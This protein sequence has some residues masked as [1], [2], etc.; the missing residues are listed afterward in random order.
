MVQ[1]ARLCPCRLPQSLPCGLSDQQRR[2]Q[3]GQG[4]RTVMRARFGAPVPVRELQPLFFTVLLLLA[5]S[6][7]GRQHRRRTIVS[8]PLS[9]RIMQ[10]SAAPTEVSIR[11]PMRSVGVPAIRAHR[12]FGGRSDARR[13]GARG[14]SG[15][16]ARR[17]ARAGYA[18]PRCQ[19]QSG[20]GQVD[21]PAPAKRVALERSSTNAADKKSYSNGEPE[22]QSH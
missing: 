5:A 7:P 9:A 15:L 14:D 8:P 20:G 1:H 16:P 22:A 13:P 21:L 6:Y 18:W 3:T 11:A 19:D 4:D 10:R 12:Q 2:H 17:G